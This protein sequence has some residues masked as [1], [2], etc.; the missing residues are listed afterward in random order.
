MTR[1]PDPG[2][3]SEE[4]RLMADRVR[5]RAAHLPLGADLGRLAADALERSG[6][7]TAAEIRQLAADTITQAQEAAWL[8]GRLA[9]LLEDG[10]GEPHD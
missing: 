3:V 2:E 9:T 6:D 8:L 1:K 4:T 10:G 7:M 5:Q